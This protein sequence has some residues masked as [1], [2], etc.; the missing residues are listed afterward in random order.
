MPSAPLQSW[1]IE[2]IR[3]PGPAPLLILLHG[4]GANETSLL[5]LA[6]EL[7]PRYAKLVVRSPLDFGPNAFGW[8]HVAFTPAGPVHDAAEAEAG[9]R[10]LADFIPEAARAHGA[11]PERVC[12]LGF[13]QGAIMAMSVLL[14]RPDLVAGALAWS[15]RILPEAVQQCQTG[16][17][18]ARRDALVIHGL[19]DATL[20]VRHG[21]ASRDT[22]AGLG[23]R[24]VEYQELA[25]GHEVTRESLALT[26]RWLAQ[27][28]D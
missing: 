26:Q 5:D 10:Q 17:V 7:D 14:T 3:G 8:F 2:P 4:V 23:L 18:L 22:L 15:G 9:R 13:S 20:P 16:P 12:L 28:L 25:M 27:R 19:H 1:F 6:P 24:S 11:D 21:R